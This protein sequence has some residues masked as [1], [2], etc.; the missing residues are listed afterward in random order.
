MIVLAL[1]C[2]CIVMPLGYRTMARQRMMRARRLERAY[3]GDDEVEVDHMSHRR[4]PF[5]YHDSS[6]SSSTQFLGGGAFVP[7]CYSQDTSA[8]EKPP[9]YVPGGQMAAASADEHEPLP[10]YEM[11]ETNSGADAASAAPHHDALDAARSA[12]TISLTSA[13]AATTTIAV[14]SEGATIPNL[15]PAPASEELDES[16]A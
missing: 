6:P 12:T 9:P 7:P 11:L 16:C 14:E 5:P 13:A 8:Y 2:C 10:S 4:L 15:A 3:R 1:C